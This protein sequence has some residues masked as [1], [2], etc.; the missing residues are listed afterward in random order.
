MING[1]IITISLCLIILALLV[2]EGSKSHPTDEQFKEWLN[3]NK[4]K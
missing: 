4:N 1:I 2:R 3:N